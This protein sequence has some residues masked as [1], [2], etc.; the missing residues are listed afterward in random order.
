M[1]KGLGEG[2]EDQIVVFG[3]EI[4]TPNREGMRDS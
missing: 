3:G 4:V 1:N 2:Q